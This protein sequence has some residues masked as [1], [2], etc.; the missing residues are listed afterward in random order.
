MIVELDRFMVAELP[1]PI[2]S[3]GDRRA[4]AALV[5]AANRLRDP[6]DKEVRPADPPRDI[7]EIIATQSDLANWP[8]LRGVVAHPVLTPDGRV[9][10]ERGYD[11]DTGLLIEITSSWPIP[12]APTRDDAVAAWVRLKELL[13]HYPWVSEVDRAVALSL[14]LTAIA[15]PVLPAAPMHCVDS[16]E[17][18]S[19]KSL[20]VNVASILASGAPASVMDFGRDAVEAGKR[21]DAMM[22]AGD[23]IIAIDNVEVPLEGAVL[24]QMLTQPARRIRVLGTHTVVTVPCVQMVT[25]SGC[26]I[27]LRGDIVRRSIIC[28]LD[29]HAERPEWRDIDQDLIAE[30]RERRRELVADIITVMLAYQRA[31][32]PATGASPLGGFGA[33]SRTVR[34]ALVWAG[35]ADPCGVMDRIR[36][37][38]PSR[39]NFTGLLRRQAPVLARLERPGRRAVD[40]FRAVPGRRGDLRPTPGGGKER[41]LRDPGRYGLPGYSRRAPRHHHHQPAVFPGPPVFEEVAKRSGHGGVSAAPELPRHGEAQTVLGCVSADTPVHHHPSP[42]VCERGLGRAVS[43]TR[44]PVLKPRR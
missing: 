36:G 35:E 43:M 28:R 34:Q 3:A 20:L 37:D 23:L 25:A 2:P 14:L 27:T 32:Q 41:P 19:G 8:V 39:Q 22:L 30:V 15:R 16:P 40:V 31:G 21:L 7:G 33:W 4:I 18:G 13:R 9:I 42:A 29:A 1:V 26:N 6:R 38:D 10:S 12:D 5:L 17:A 44:S 24:C 11:R